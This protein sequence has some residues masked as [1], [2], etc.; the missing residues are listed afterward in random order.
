MSLFATQQ[1]CFSSSCA[2]QIRVDFRRLA[3][4]PWHLVEGA[5]K[6]CLGN[7]KNISCLS[8][9][10]V[11]RNVC[12]FLRYMFAWECIRSSTTCFLGVVYAVTQKT[13]C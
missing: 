2:S 13:T 7:R 6:E 8:S 5:F 12:S 9:F 11:V 10:K 4:L 1:L 3:K